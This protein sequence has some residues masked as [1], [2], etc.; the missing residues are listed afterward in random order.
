MLEWLCPDA[1]SAFFATQ[2]IRAVLKSM[3]KHAEDAQVEEEA[4]R[5]PVSDARL[6]PPHCVIL[7]DTR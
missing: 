1:D 2:L 7:P 3:E 6:Y 5:L 4:A